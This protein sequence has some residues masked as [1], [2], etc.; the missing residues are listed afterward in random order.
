RVEQLLELLERASQE[1][2]APAGVH[3]DVIILRLDPIDLRD[4][5]DAHAVAG[6][7]GDALE[8]PG[9]RWRRTAL[10]GLTL[11]ERDGSI[12]PHC[13]LRAAEGPGEALVVEGLEHIIDGSGVER[14]EGMPRVGGHEH[15]SRG[16]APG[17]L[18]DLEAADAGH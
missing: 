14:L 18:H 4:G 6:R 9:L 12:R 11:R 3:L 16:T 15:D 1:V 8:V 10:A 5:H 2:T 13:R 17:R 7:N